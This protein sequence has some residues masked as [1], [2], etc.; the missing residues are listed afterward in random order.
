MLLSLRIFHW[1]TVIR[2]QNTWIKRKALEKTYS[3][4][5]SCPWSSIFK[6]RYMTPR[7]SFFIPYPSNK[8]ASW[9]CHSCTAFLLPYR[10][11]EQS[12]LSF[13][14][15]SFLISECRGDNK[16]GFAYGFHYKEA[17]APSLRRV[18]CF[19]MWCWSCFILSSLLLRCLL[20]QSS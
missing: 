13:S 9:G 7:V 1:T 17:D 8:E 5:S 14:F 6:M 20:N 12:I 2:G 3:S 11:S 15:K 18:I 19:Y 10:Y 4:L 16:G